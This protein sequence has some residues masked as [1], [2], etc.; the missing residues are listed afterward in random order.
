MY[1][2]CVGILSEVRE[3]TFGGNFIPTFGVSSI[4]YVFS[5]MKEEEF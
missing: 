5:P 2:P 3:E 4:F 1:V